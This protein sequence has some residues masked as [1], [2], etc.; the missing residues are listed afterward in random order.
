MRT[1]TGWIA[2][3]LPFHK[4]RRPDGLA[5]MVRDLIA[6]RKTLI[7][8]AT[9]EHKMPRRWELRYDY[10]LVKGF[11]AEMAACDYCRNDFTA[12]NMYCA[13]D[14]AYHQEMIRAQRSIQ[15]TRARERAAMARDRRFLIMT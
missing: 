1:K 14:G 13:V 2:K 8:C 7:L 4:W 6:L 3:A 11:H 5:S 15:E 9:C 10:A 12:T